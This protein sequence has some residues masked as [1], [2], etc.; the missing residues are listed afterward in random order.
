MSILFL[1]FKPATKLKHKQLW[2]PY[3]DLYMYIGMPIEVSK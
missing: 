1:S 3:D 2:E